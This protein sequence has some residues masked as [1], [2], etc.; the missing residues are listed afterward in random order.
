MIMIFHPITHLVFINGLGRLT[1]LVLNIR[2][3][4]HEFR[5]TR[6]VKSCFPWNVPFNIM[7]QMFWLDVWAIKYNRRNG[8]LVPWSPDPPSSPWPLSPALHM[9]HRLLLGSPGLSCFWSFNCLEF[10]LNPP[11]AHTGFSSNCARSCKD[12]LKRT[13]NTIKKNMDHF[14][15][16]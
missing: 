12:H 1:N 4:L 15:K 2:V 16:S 14:G 6:K 5:N 7:R 11:N 3:C 9:L 8:W 13:K 10:S